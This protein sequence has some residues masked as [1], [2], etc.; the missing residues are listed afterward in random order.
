LLQLDLGA[1]LLLL[2]GQRCWI[3]AVDKGKLQGRQQR[4]AAAAVALAAEMRQQLAAEVGS[5]L[6]PELA[7][8]QQQQMQMQPLNSRARLLT[9]MWK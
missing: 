2:H 9:Q 8:Q 5:L 3:R 6:L 4:A 7:L 1:R